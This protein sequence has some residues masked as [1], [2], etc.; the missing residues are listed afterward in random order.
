MGSERHCAARF[1]MSHYNVIFFANE[2]KSGNGTQFAII[3]SDQNNREPFISNVGR[4]K[5]F[6]VKFADHLLKVVVV[7][8][9][10]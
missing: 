5:I 10:E 1:F 3:L 6:H 7:G 4:L 2:S 8:C 9:F